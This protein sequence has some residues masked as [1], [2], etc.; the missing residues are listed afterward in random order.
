MVSFF[1][2]IAKIVEVPFLFFLII[3]FIIVLEV[4]KLKPHSLGILLSS[5]I[6]DPIFKSLAAA[7]IEKKK[8]VKKR[9]KMH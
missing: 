2:L 7:T 6:I 1:E 3:T 4:S 9:K 5:F 8:Y